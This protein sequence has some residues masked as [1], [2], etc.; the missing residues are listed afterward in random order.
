MEVCRVLEVK[1][2]MEMKREMLRALCG[3]GILYMGE[4]LESY[5][6]DMGKVCVWV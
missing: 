1:E 2:G 4:E 3:E 6:M 5:M